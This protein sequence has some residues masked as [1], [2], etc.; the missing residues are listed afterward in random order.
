MKESI[1]IFRGFLTAIG[2]SQC[3]VCVS[4]D[5]WYRYYCELL[6]VMLFFTEIECTL[7]ILEYWELVHYLVKT[8]QVYESPKNCRIYAL[9]GFPFVFCAVSAEHIVLTLC[10]SLFFLTFP[11]WPL[12]FLPELCWECQWVR[13]LMVTLVHLAPASS[14]SLTHLDSETL[15][16]WCHSLKCEQPCLASQLM[17]IEPHSNFGLC[18]WHMGTRS[19]FYEFVMSYI[20]KVTKTNSKVLVSLYKFRCMMSF[21][22]VYVF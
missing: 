20:T 4:H 21:S 12:W 15:W 7:S 3:T 11:C 10:I 6:R 17:Y 18:I 19:C 1:G 5:T 13:Y 14:F 2:V 22:S 16:T 9:C 8:V